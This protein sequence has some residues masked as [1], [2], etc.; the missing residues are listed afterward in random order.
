MFPKPTEMPR[1]QYLQ[2]V[3]Q[4]AGLSMSSWPMPT[5]EDFALIGAF[6]VLYSYIDFNLKRL[7]DGLEHIHRIPKAKKRRRRTTREIAE[8]VQSADWSA[9]NRAAL[10]RIEE[11]RGIRNLLA[12]CAIR[13]FPEDDAFAFLFK[14]AEDYKEHF[15][16]E[17]PFGV[18]MTAVMDRA[19]LLTIVPEVENLQIWLSQVTTQFED[20]IEGVILKQPT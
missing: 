19:Q 2:G 18:S 3:L 20:Q 10:E 6:V 9:E 8:A 5:K 16:G 4:N 14:S 1:G 13:R 17:A 7:V 11:F 15:G 12:H